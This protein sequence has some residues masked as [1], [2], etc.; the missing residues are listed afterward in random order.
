MERFDERELDAV[1]EVIRSGELSRFFN[2]FAGGK[3]VQAFEEEFANYLG[4]KYA[5]SVS[6]GTVALEVAL[7]AL[8][9]KLGD[10]VITTPLTFIATATAIL[11][12]GAKPVFVDIDPET[13]NMDELQV[14]DSITRKTKAI[15]SVSLLGKPA[16]MSILQSIANDYHLTLVEDAAQALGTRSDL[17]QGAWRG[18]SALPSHI[19][20]VSDIATFSFQESKSITSGGEGG[21]IATDSDELADLCRHIRNHGNTYGTLEMTQPCTN[22][23]MTEMQAAFGRVQLTKL[24]EFILI[25]RKNAQVLFDNLK[26]PL[27]PVYTEM[28]STYYLI[29]YYI[30]PDGVTKFTDMIP[31][32]AV[33]YKMSRDEFIEKCRQAGVSKGIP[34][35]NIGYYKKLVYDNPIFQ[36]YKPKHGCMN[37]EWARD[38]ILLF[39]VH[40]WNKTPEDMVKTAEVINKITQDR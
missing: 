13:L 3:N 30:D 31:S 18:N 20:T 39:D 1:A 38:N 12:V 26:Q 37:A 24:D 25:Q 35:Q 4:C 21:M 17:D 11:C 33:Q 40:R 36:K 7:A 8:D 34:G 16:R 10:E 23:R 14:E 27:I 32:Y 22:A 28:D 15:L 29:P 6:N 9:L 5:V 19:G 2:S